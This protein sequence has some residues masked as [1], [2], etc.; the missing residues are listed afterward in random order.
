LGPV[1]L[2]PT[3]WVIRGS[4]LAE[5]VDPDVKTLAGLGR[6]DDKERDM[7]IIVGRA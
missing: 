5:L 3:A 2:A 1:T 4:Q 6:P 7:A